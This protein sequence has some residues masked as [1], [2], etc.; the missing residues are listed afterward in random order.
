MFAERFGLSADPFRITADPSFLYFGQGHKDALSAV[1]LSVLESRGI[2]ALTAPA[3]MGKT[4]LLR[5]LVG[6]LK[7]KAAAAFFP[8]PYQTRQDVMQEVM[9]RVGLGASGTAEFEQMSRLQQRLAELK[10]RGYRML[11]LFDEGQAL[12]DEA[13]EQIRLL[14]NLH[15]TNLNLLEI[16]I[17]GQ[18]ELEDKLRES[19]HEALRQRIS[20]MARVEPLREDEVAE[21]IQ[22]RLSV[23][24]RSEELFLPEAIKLA[25]EVSGGI[26]RWLNH[27]CHGAL[28]LAWA[29]DLDRVTAD[30][31]L[32]ASRELPRAASP[33]LVDQP[34][35]PRLMPTNETNSGLQ[36]F[37]KAEGAGD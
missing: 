33:E 23:V 2:G 1:Y 17:A 19:R 35:A 12:S 31:V 22:H 14:S 7:G 26:P 9:R 6:R 36:A 11:L 10:R 21:Y 28:T 16:I 29:D 27:V 30:L 32:E 3:G 8:H 4:T 24:G 13:L 25:A 20:V 37:G 18:P 5:Y 34:E 15:S